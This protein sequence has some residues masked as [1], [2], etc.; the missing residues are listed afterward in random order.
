MLI[1]VFTLGKWTCSWQSKQNDKNK[2]PFRE[3]LNCLA[4]CCALYPSDWMPASGFKHLPWS[5]ALQTHVRNTVNKFMS[6][7]AFFFNSQIFHCAVKNEIELLLVVK[8]WIDARMQI[9]MKTKRPIRGPRMMT[10][11]TCVM[12]DKYHVSETLRSNKKNCNL[13]PLL[14][15]LL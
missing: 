1:N 14:D 9:S 13:S 2:D 8:E 6:L 5:R 4:T 7:R 12:D 3:S 11:G 15:M 10:D